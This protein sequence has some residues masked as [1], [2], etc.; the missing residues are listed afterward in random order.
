MDE[1][2]RLF[3]LNERTKRAMYFSLTNEIFINVLLTILFLFIVSFKSISQLENSILCILYFFNIFLYLANTRLSSHQKQLNMDISN[4]YL[5]WK[6]L[7]KK[8]KKYSDIMVL[9]SKNYGN[10]IV[11]TNNIG[12][13]LNL[14]TI[15]FF[16]LIL[17]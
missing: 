9:Q 2:D 4:L 5:Q 1:R 12:Y 7:T 13:I 11:L 10:K 16:I 17:L 8:E 15:L 6:K 14:A 3:D